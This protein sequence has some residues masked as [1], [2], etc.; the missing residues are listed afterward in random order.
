MKF[1]KRHLLMLT[2]ALFVISCNNQT[3]NEG[4]EVHS[5]HEKNESA[6]GAIQLNNGEKWAVN[7][8][9]KPYILEARAILYEYVENDTDD[10][11]MLAA[12]LKEK[13][14]GLIQSCTMTGESHDELHKWLHPHMELIASLDQAQNI[15]A[16][17]PII[18]RL[19]QSFETY[20]QHFQ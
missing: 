20:H 4:Q 3:N 2:I 18:A 8:E 6:T 5:M 7:E 12:Q 9:M 1:L 17:Q 15:D 13:N 14:S 10:Y 16:A 11:K 19:K